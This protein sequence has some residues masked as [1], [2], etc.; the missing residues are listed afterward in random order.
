MCPP[1]SPRC[2]ALFQ[3]ARSA[4]QLGSATQSRRALLAYTAR[5]KL[6][7]CAAGRERLAPCLQSTNNTATARGRS[8]HIHPDASIHVE[9]LAFEGGGDEIRSLAW[10]PYGL[11]LASCAV[12]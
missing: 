12:D 6:A 1:P 7:V 8:V 9:L 10:S 3:A 5:F 11:A 2:S 4:T